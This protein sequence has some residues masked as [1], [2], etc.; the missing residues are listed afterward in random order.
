MRQS[1]LASTAAVT[2]LAAVASC[3]A[4][5]AATSDRPNASGTMTVDG[6]TSPL[7]HAFVI[8]Q[9]PEPEHLTGF[10]KV[11]IT[12]EPVPSAL[13]PKLQAE[14]KRI[15]PNF[16]EALAG[17][18]IRGL[19]LV[20]AKE[21]PETNRHPYIAWLFAADTNLLGG[22][23]G[24][25]GDLDEFSAREGIVT[26]RASSEWTHPYGL[27]NDGDRDVACAFSVSF[28][29]RSVGNFV[30][31]AVPHDG[32]PRVPVAG[33]ASGTLQ[34]KERTYTLTTAY[35]IGKRIFYDEPEEMVY[36]LVADQPVEGSAL[37]DLLLQG[38]NVL[39]ERPG[40]HAIHLKVNQYGTI[41]VAQALAVEGGSCGAGYG[42]LDSKQS[43]MEGGRVIGTAVHRGRDGE[44]KFSIDFD[45]PIAKK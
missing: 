14:A 23:W 24:D 44:C 5:S 38:T 42:L 16:H 10:V 15:A 29:A 28:E 11:L 45:A 19:M 3:A 40:V 13:L 26:G 4:P 9:Q 33:K 41:S 37:R 12:N 2:L 8:R 36:V 21:I 35:A 30:T 6:K 34:V 22:K 7:R 25:R 17:T 39:V 18:S 32:L 20:L 31:A 27:K 1:R 43:R